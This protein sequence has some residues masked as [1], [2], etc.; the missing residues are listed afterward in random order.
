MKSN[1]RRAPTMEDVADEAG[2][3]RA[4]VSLVM[5]RAPNVSEQ[6]RSAVL[7]AAK[8][9]DYRPNAAAR[10]LAQNRSNTFGV[11]LDDL[12]NP[13]FADLVDGIH[14]VAD[15][16]GYQVQLNSGRLQQDGERRAI[17]S[18]LE[19]Q[20]D[21]IIILGTRASAASLQSINKVAPIVSLGAG[22]E[23]IDSVFN[24]D[25][26][27]AELVVDHLA[28]LG[29]TDIVHIA[30]GSGGGAKL[31]RAGFEQTMRKRGLTPR[32]VD[33]DY[34][35]LSAVSAVEVLLAERSIPTAIFAANDV[36]AVAAL[37]RLQHAKLRVPQD[38]SIIGY[39]NTSLAALHHISLSTI[40][41]PRL[42]MGRHAAQC[43]I[44]RLD[45][46][47]K[48]P[49]QHMVSPSLITRLTTG[50]APDRRSSPSS[51]NHPLP[52]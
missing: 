8:K 11:V 40:N 44:E 27:G 28:D 48:A 49:V 26:R 4:L 3:S 10:S 24:D 21:G 20:V 25:E 46:G 34:S 50:P 1:G 13:F 2:V 52:L 29:H 32:V 18:F 43:L 16:H 38:V 45:E 31:R 23:G 42:E 41:Q 30:G 37:N 17:E 33:G 22:I 9:L 47:R 19:Y 6:R 12:H 7:T 51:P 15:K 35:D 14:E 36:M 5:R 39:D